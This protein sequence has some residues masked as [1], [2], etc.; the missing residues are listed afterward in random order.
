M[1][2]EHFEFL[3]LAVRKMRNFFE[4]VI[5]RQYLIGHDGDRILVR[6]GEREIRVDATGFLLTRD[7]RDVYGLIIKRLGTA[8]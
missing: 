2:A 3:D 6:R 7:P 1:D 8:L 4:R 5:P